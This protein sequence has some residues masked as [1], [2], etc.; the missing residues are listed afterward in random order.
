MVLGQPL[1][2][3]ERTHSFVGTIAYMAPEVLLGAEQTL[4]VDFW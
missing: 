4:S 1:P 3:G 2:Y